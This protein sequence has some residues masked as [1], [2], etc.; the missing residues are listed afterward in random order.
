MTVVVYNNSYAILTVELLRTGAGK[1]GDKAQSLLSLDNPK[2]NWVEMAH[3]M[4]VSASR[5]DT[6][7]EFRSAFSEAMTQ[8]GPRLIESCLVEVDLAAALINL[9]EVGV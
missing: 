7:E 9:S 2:L 8:R 6:I 1:G 5:V 3:G 4:G